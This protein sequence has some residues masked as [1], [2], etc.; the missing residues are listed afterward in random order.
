MAGSLPDSFL[1]EVIRTRIRTR[2]WTRNL[3]LES[4]L[5]EVDSEKH[6]YER[7]IGGLTRVMKHSKQSNYQLDS[8]VEAKK[9]HRRPD[10][11]HI[12][13]IRYTH[14]DPYTDPYTEPYTD[15]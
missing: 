8:S 15:P 3:T 5:L 10:I 6:S 9:L 7:R 4:F 2:I 13:P 1:V 11:T 14:T 12:Y